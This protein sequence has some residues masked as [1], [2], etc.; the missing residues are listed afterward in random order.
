MAEIALRSEKNNRTVLKDVIPL[1]TPYLMGIFLGDICNFRCKYC[2]QS[3]DD[4]TTE[5]KD[6]K[7]RFLDWNMFVRIVDS[8]K[9]FPHKIKKILL[10][11]IGEPLL[12]PHVIEM[13][14]Y[15]KE[16]DLAGE[17]EI[18]SNASMLT[19]E[20]TEGLVDAG[21][22]RLCLS[23][24]GLDAETYR[25]VCG[26]EVDYD[27]FYHNIKYFYEYSRGKCRLHI[28]TVDMALKDGEESRFYEM[29]SPICDTI[30]IDKVMPV[31]KGVDYSG[32]V[33]DTSP[34][35]QERFA[36]LQGLCC[37]PI[38]YTLYTLADGTVAPCCDHPQPTTFG[39]IMERSLPEI[40][41]GPERKEF[42]LMHLNHNRCQNEICKQC[43]AP[44]NRKFDED[45]L[46][47]YEE[48]IKHRIL[49]D[50]VQ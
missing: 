32:I 30:H 4:S 7:R 47:G 13:V 28:K 42:L 48:E 5:K 34:F 39:N 12:N 24:Q 2:I 27:T 14:R 9:Q 46:D 22:T 16:V 44:L 33:K 43:H 17:Y 36:E 3:A 31:F 38:F 49:M 8:A 20:M 21:L 45:I 11:S 1:D 26:Y 29:Y 10:S 6:L 35:T 23:L 50:S 41:N 15:M 37:S 18:V 40:W 25:E 19:K